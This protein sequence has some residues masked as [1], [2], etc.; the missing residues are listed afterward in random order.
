MG[1]IRVTLIGF[2]LFFGLALITRYVSL[3]SIVAVSS[4]IVSTLIF[5]HT[6][7][8]V[9]LWP[10][11]RNNQIEAYIL[12]MIFIIFVL[13]RHRE[14]IKRLLNGTE[15]KLGVKEA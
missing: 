3:G 5:N 12:I 6:N 11:N 14:N 1:D 15:R 4:L 2:G 10:E 13:V 7:N 8:P 9:H